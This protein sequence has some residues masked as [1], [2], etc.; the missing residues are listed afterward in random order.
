MQRARRLASTAVVAALAVSGLSACGRA[1]PDVAAY[2][3]GGQKI[4]EA[5]VEKVYDQAHDD[6]TA[7]RGKIQQQATTGASADPAAPV[8]VPFK[9]QDVLNA[10][11]TIDVLEQSAAA[12][13]VQPAAEP[14]VEQIAQGSSYSP[15]WEYTK[16]YART[17]QLRAALL[18]KVTPA[19]LTDAELRPVYERLT[20]GGAGDATP[21]E[22]FKTQLSDQNKQALQQSIGLRNEVAKIIADDQIKVNPRFGEQ[23]LVL[24]SAQ[25]GNKDVPLVEV[26]FASE[27]PFV[28]DVS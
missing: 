10:L 6:L 28:T 4:T 14:T 21:Y 3:G 11:L 1:Q 26:S 18:P 23:K 25:A 8:E 15:T 7:S 27:T 5:Q 9:Q 24:L 16:L 12:K 22:Q 17:F 13:G 2:L 19:E 20:A